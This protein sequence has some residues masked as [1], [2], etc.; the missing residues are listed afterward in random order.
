MELGNRESYIFCKSFLEDMLKRR[1]NIPLSITTDGSPKL[2]KAIDEV[3]P[4]SLRIRCWV[5]KM[6]NLSCKVPRYVW[7]K[8]KREIIA[9]RDAL[10]YEEGKERLEAFI[11]KYERIYPSLVKCLS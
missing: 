2:I 10:N 5:H 11:S 1:L 6:N 7:E 9:I 4:Q 3:F 8:I